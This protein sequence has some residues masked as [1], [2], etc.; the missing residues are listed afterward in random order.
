MIIFHAFVGITALASGAWNL[1]TKKGTGLHRAMGYLY[2]I[3]M[4]ALVITSFFIYEVFSSFGPFHIMSIVS[5]VTLIMALY[6][7]IRR[8]KYENWLEHHYM[9]ISWSYIGLL[10]ATGSH[11]FQYGPPGWPF[12]AR[13]VLYWALPMV[14]GAFLIY[15]NRKQ[16]LALYS[17]GQAS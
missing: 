10:M 13:A 6:F 4:A 9:W 15:W 3:S 1:S 7:P 17:D 5:G 12:W 14:C 16:T 2:V 11:L 8:E